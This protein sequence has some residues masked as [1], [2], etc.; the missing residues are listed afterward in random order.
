VARFAPW[1]VAF[2]LAAVSVPVRTAHACSCYFPV[3]VFPN[4]R[5]THVASNTKFWVY[6][7]ELITCT[8]GVSL[9]D[10]EG[11]AVPGSARDF[12]QGFPQWVVF[13]PDVELD[14][15]ASYT[16][17]ACPGNDLPGL[18]TITVS[19]ADDRVAPEVPSATAAGHSYEDGTGEN[20]GGYD[21]VPIAI[22][23]ESEIAVLDIGSTATL[24]SGAL[25][26]AVTDASIDARSEEDFVG[27]S[28]CRRNWSF[29]RSCTTTLRVGGID[30]A[31]NFSGWSRSIDIDACGE[32]TTSSTGE[33]ATTTGTGGGAPAGSGGS[34]AGS[35]G[36]DAQTDA[37]S[38]C[39][40]RLAE[41]RRAGGG[42]LFPLALGAALV[43]WLRGRRREHFNQ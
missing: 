3:V 10:A 42:A 4:G 11:N 33:G 14:V 22:D 25:E 27:Y 39:A 28:Q 43:G 5:T 21:V 32:A 1:L 37:D 26:G 2:G 9:T 41:Q 16:L 35:N 20:C 19:D 12:A 31:G 29:E 17:S 7:T 30:F 34:A 8:G 15:G 38:G 40:C 13:T 6:G 18:V 23:H 24:D 36:A